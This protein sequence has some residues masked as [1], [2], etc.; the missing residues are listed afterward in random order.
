[1]LYAQTSLFGEDVT[2]GT[3]YDNLRKCDCGATPRPVNDDL[4][5]WFECPVCKRST[6]VF[7]SE[8]R[9]LGAWNWDITYESKGSGVKDG[10]TI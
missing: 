5:W 3:D 4:V 9:A 6:D 8:E 7:F 10:K 1:M 2:V